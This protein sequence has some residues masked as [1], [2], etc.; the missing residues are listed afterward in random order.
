MVSAE[1]NLPAHSPSSSSS[2]KEA[3]PD[4]ILDDQLIEIDEGIFN[5]A[6]EQ[7]SAQE[8]I[9]ISRHDTINGQTAAYQ[10]IKNLAQ[11][12]VKYG[13]QTIIPVQNSS[14]SFF[15]NFSIKLDDYL[16]NEGNGLGGLYVYMNSENSIVV[17][18]LGLAD[19]EQVELQILSSGKIIN[20]T[21]Y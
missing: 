6:L 15:N 2:V 17:E 10:P 14:Q 12:A 21:I 5:I 18:L 8:I 9:T 19:D 1:A 4:I 20:D 16:P 7:L 3:T 13:P 11:L